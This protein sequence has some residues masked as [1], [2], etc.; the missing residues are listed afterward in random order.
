MY[1]LIVGSVS[2]N[3]QFGGLTSDPFTTRKRPKPSSWLFQAELINQ[4][5]FIPLPIAYSLK[6]D[7]SHRR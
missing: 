6:K 4:C 5:Q 2:T 1:Q 3:S 7:K